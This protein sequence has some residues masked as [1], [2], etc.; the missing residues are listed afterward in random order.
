M[1][2]TGGP[3]PQAY[4]VPEDT[5]DQLDPVIMADAARALCIAVINIA[6]K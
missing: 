6:N 4:H 5:I 2:A 1:R 3:W